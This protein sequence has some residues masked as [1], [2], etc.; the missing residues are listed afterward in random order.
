MRWFPR[1]MENAKR[2]SGF[3]YSLQ[4]ICICSSKLSELDQVKI[5]SEKSRISK[6]NFGTLNQVFPVNRV[7]FIEI[8]EYQTNNSEHM[9]N[10]RLITATKQ[11]N[12]I[13]LSRQ[14]VRNLD[15]GLH[16]MNPW[17]EI[18]VAD[19]TSKHELSV[20]LINT[21]SNPYRYDLKH[22]RNSTEERRG[23]YQWKQNKLRTTF[24]YN[25]I[26]TLNLKKVTYTLQIMQ[27]IFLCH[28]IIYVFILK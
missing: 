28:N 9:I 23:N 20:V 13:V 16:D 4:N 18:S 5:V 7:I 3:W 22:A 6:I 8:F 12:N 17:I 19:Q 11:M 10:K 26:M 1:P 24:L 2:L 14:N 25:S 15:H 21:I 27:I